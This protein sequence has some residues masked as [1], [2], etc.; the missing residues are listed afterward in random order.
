[1][2]TYDPVY[3]LT[4]YAPYSTDPTETTVLTPIAGAPHSDPFVLTSVQGIAGSKPY[5]GQ[6]TGRRGELDP[7]NKKVTVGE[8]TIPAFDVRVSA[9]GSNATRWITA[10][11]G[12]AGGAQQ[13]LN[14]RAVLEESLDG[15]ATWP[16]TPFFSGRIFGFDLARGAVQMTLT[17]REQ[18]VG[19]NRRA[20]VG[21]PHSSIA[22]AAMGQ[23]YPL[24][25]P[26]DWQNVT[27]TP[28]LDGVVSYQY[29]MGDG[30]TGGAVDV[31]ASV[32]PHLTLITKYANDNDGDWRNLRAIV[33]DVVAGTTGVFAFHS[34]FVQKLKTIKTTGGSHYSRRSF[35]GCDQLT[36]T[37]M[38]LP[39]L[40]RAVKFSITRD[41][42]PVDDCPLFISNVHPVQ[43]WA[44]ILDGKFSAMDASGNPRPLAPRDSSVGGPWDTLIN[45]P[46]YPL[47][48]F[49]IGS[50]LAN[51]DAATWIEK[52]ICQV[53]QLTYRLDGAGHVVPI[54][55]RRAGI[56]PA[57]TITDADRADGTAPA[58]SVTR[59]GA[60]TGVEF[61]WYADFLYTAAEYADDTATYP[62]LPPA[63]VRSVEQ[64]DVVPVDLSTLLDVG[65]N[66]LQVDGRGL[67][68]AQAALAV[69]SGQET[70]VQLADTQQRVIAAAAESMA[71]YSGGP[72]TL[73]LACRRTANVAPVQPG[74][75]VV[76]QVTTQPDPA[77]NQRGGPRLMLCLARA[78]RGPNI[79]FRFL[80][81][82]AN[83]TAATPVLGTGV[84]DGGDPTQID[85]GVTVNA[86]GDPVTLSAAV[87]AAG[88]AGRPADDSPLWNKAATVDATGTAI[89]GP[90]PGSRR[91]WLRGRSEPTGSS[92]K[93]PSAWVA[94][95]GSGYVDITALAAPSAVTIANIYGS[96]ADA[97]WTL[98]DPTLQVEVFLA[99]GGVPGSWTVDQ[100]VA[101]LDPGS[102]QIH[103]SGLVPSTAYTVGVRT[104][105]LRGGTSAMATASFST[106][107]TS[108]TLAAPLYPQAWAGA[109]G[110]GGTALAVPTG[111]YGIAVVAAELPGTVEVAEAVET[112]PGSGTYGGFA[113][114]GTVASVLGT[115]TMWRGTAPN[116]GCRRQLK[117]RHIA[118]NAT[119][120]AY[121]DPVT[122]LPWTPLALPAYPEQIFVQVVTLDPSPS[123]DGG[124]L[125]RIQV[126]AT[127]PAGGAPEVEITALSS[128]VTIDTGPA[129]NTLSPNDQIWKVTMPASSTGPGNLTVEAHLAGK[130]A[131]ASFVVPP[132][133]F[134]G[135][136]LT[137]TPTPGTS[138]YSIAWSG[139]GTITLSIDGGGYSTPPASPIVV[140][141]PSAGS[142]PHQYSFKAVDGSQTVTDSVTIPALDA[143][144]VTPDLSVVVGTPTATTIPM[145]VTALNPGPGVA[146]ITIT[147]SCSKCS[148]T[149]GAT[150][151]PDGSSVS[152]GSGTVVTANRPSTTQVEQ[153][154]LKFR[155]SIAGGGAEEIQRTVANQFGT[156]PTLTVTPTPGSSSYSIAYTGTGTITYSVDGGSYTTPPASPI[157]VT[158]DGS[159][160]TYTFKAVLNGQ[161]VT[162]PVA[163]PPADAAGGSWTFALSA[164]GASNNGVTGPPYN[165]L[166]VNFS[167]SGF[168]SGTTFDASYDNGNGNMGNSDG[169]SSSPI[170]F[171]GVTF[172]GTPGRG[173][174]TVSAQY[175][176][177]TL[178]TKTRNQLYTT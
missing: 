113:T 93:I 84:V 15:G 56:A 40:G 6:P 13:L 166:D 148:M 34:R 102:I 54:D 19:L 4:V 147:V 81:A 165:Q 68:A 151:Y 16:A 149:I 97:S 109:Y 70:Q 77:S 42:P 117:A 150:T 121:C 116:D 104:R 128:N 160:H 9:G 22:Y 115:W 163:I 26:I 154:T 91:V 176:G 85:L 72:A 76:V 79:D 36:P 135:P 110:P 12:D 94:S 178:A 53:Y 134:A 57:I 60:V 62:D 69:V 146:I 30:T 88:T 130:T 142:A 173:S 170:T 21:I 124:T 27:A 168:P 175:N 155:A 101:L 161:T 96:E 7:Q 49:L 111:D 106:S 2:S 144:T 44:D 65:E 47:A 48:N 78:E 103:L 39:A 41:A 8:I 126:H 43:L 59:Q 24:G 169:H 159:G 171:T 107:A 32:D 75:W 99:V 138:S 25:V 73:P 63:L 172:N 87:T 162:V 118:V 89:I 51:V 157:S 133:S 177:K 141:R 108:V 37:S 100:R 20:F 67:R 82:G 17:L 164:C 95:G 45:D 125:L 61:K 80:D 158:L 139:T 114:V 52:Y 28:P 152:V 112:A 3:R 86:S 23:L 74:T 136:S 92:L 143:N 71:P 14:L 66:L 174:V 5:L 58:W 18:S 46:S 98:S 50:D 10:F 11:I 33:T 145:T 83:S 31:D 64:V 120:S 35:G 105:D 140:S 131:S 90:F 137:V 132:Q 38:A 127:D 122:V 119:P 1:M 129:L 156:G 55:L 153:G 167:A 29:T 123:T